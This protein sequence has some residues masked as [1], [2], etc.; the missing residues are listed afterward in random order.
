M[1]VD[2]AFEEA[3]AS[4]RNLTNLDTDTLLR[5]YSLYKQATI[6]VCN[7]SRPSIFSYTARQK[8]DAWNSLGSLSSSEAKVRYVEL[9]GSLDTNTDESE[10][11]SK[12]SALG[13]AVSCMAKTEEELDDSD[14]NIF[15][16]LKE[17]NTQQVSALLEKIPSL[18]SQSDDDG[19]TLLHWSADRGNT[20][21]IQLLA[22][23]GA[24][25]NA[26]DTAGQTA[27]HYAYACG[28]GDCIRLLEE[29]GADPNIR[30]ND[31]QLPNELADA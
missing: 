29:R 2:S 7:I 21:M 8:W 24:N 11:K 25:V 12:P 4:A 15:D 22:D 17:G 6:G 28:H 27:L 20:S 14:K 16:W 26:V 30:D 5:L 3:T 1:D 18:L 31:G 13:V 9:V 23:K 10:K 19:M